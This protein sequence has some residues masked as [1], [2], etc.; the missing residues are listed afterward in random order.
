MQATNSSRGK[1]NLAVGKS[2]LADTWVN[3]HP[4]IVS[5]VNIDPLISFLLVVGWCGASLAPHFPV[6]MDFEKWGR[7]FT[8]VVMGFV[9]A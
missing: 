9:V 3:C 2:V 7:L 5:F 6:Y 1:C 4:R 8:M